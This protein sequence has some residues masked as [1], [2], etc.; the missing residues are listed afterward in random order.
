MSIEE[1]TLSA[2]W[3]KNAIC[4]NKPLASDKDIVKTAIVFTGYPY[5]NLKR[6][7][8]INKSFNNRHEVMMKG[9]QSVD[10]K[11]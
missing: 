9:T 5:R 3:T 2:Q 10:N 4:E 1:E 8:I 6:L 11:K 7:Y